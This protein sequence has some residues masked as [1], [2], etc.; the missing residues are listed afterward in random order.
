M[1]VIKF[2]DPNTKGYRTL[3]F[4]IGQHFYSTSEQI[5]G[6]WI[7]GE[8]I[9]EITSKTPPTSAKEILSTTQI[10]GYNVYVYTKK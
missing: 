2:K 10:G 6:M 3:D 7:T 1:A 9:Y 4:P 8:T 5:A